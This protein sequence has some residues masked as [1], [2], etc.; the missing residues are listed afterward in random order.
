MT[1]KTGPGDVDVSWAYSMFFFIVSFFFYLHFF[2]ATDYDND[3]E[4]MDGA[5]RDVEQR[6][7]QGTTRKTGPYSMFFL[8]VSFFFFSLTFFF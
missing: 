1:R 7:R 6:R 3:N 2:L 5:T 4:D 8:F